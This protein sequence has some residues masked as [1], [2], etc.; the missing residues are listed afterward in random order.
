MPY[1]KGTL[2]GACCGVVL[3]F[4]IIP[5]ACATVVNIDGS[6]SGYYP[7][8][9]PIAGFSDPLQVTL[10]AGTYS[11]SD[12]YGL[13]GATF[14]AFNEH[15]TAFDDWFWHYVVGTVT[16]MVLVDVGSLLPYET[17]M[18]AAAAGHALPAATL[19][20]A[21]TTT[22]DFAVYDNFVSDNSGGISLDITPV[23]LPEPASIGLL[24]MGIAGLWLAARR[25]RRIG[26]DPRS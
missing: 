4:V 18:A 13:A 8:A 26:R 10:P 9:D 11:I 24:S 15:Y 17:E 6:I 16:G 3:S 2:T 14:D 1:R 22:L 5:Y 12:A 20:L 25:R 23:R 19:S 7:V 21:G